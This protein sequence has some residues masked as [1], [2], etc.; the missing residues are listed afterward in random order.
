MSSSYKKQMCLV[1]FPFPKFSACHKRD[2]F[3]LLND[4]F[5][6]HNLDDKIIIPGGLDGSDS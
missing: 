2:S 5:A 4:Y 1:I 6:H 3:Y